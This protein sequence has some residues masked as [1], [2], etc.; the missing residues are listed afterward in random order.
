M[1]TKTT[2]TRAHDGVGVRE[3]ARSH[4]ETDDRVQAVLR[5]GPKTMAE[6]AD[7]TG[8]C[9]STIWF[10]VKRLVNQKRVRPV[11]GPKAIIHAERRA[12][13]STRYEIDNESESKQLRVSS[14]NSEARRHPQDVALF[15]EYKRRAA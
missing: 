10:C 3:R 12:G 9:V 15:G 13:R 7:E 11:E 6:L 2:S 8:L 4:E 14:W 5:P 1:S